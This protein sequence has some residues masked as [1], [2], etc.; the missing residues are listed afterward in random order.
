[1]LGHNIQSFVCILCGKMT[2]IEQKWMKINI[3]K[4]KMQN[5]KCHLIKQMETFKMA[6]YIP[7]TITYI[8]C[9][10]IYIHALSFTSK[11]FSTISQIQMGVS[12]WQAVHDLCVNTLAFEP[13]P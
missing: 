5:K 8:L 4:W 3:N 13:V 11:N 7:N 6:L 9:L 2:A 12:L 10:F 1:M